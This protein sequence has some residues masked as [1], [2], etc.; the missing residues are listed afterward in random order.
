MILPISMGFPCLWG[1][2][3]HSIDWSYFGTSFPN[4]SNSRARTELIFTLALD[5]WF[6]VALFCYLF[7]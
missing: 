1:D 3:P 6:G 2:N 4:N 7:D 5:D